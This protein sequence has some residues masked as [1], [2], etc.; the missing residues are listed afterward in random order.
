MSNASLSKR[1]NS[2]WYNYVAPIGEI[3]TGNIMEN[4][5]IYYGTDDFE[6]YIT[7]FIA[8]NRIDSGL[9]IICR[10][11]TILASPKNFTSFIEETF[12]TFNIMQL[13]NTKGVITDN[14]NNQYISYNISDSTTHVNIFG[15]ME[16]VNSIVKIITDKFDPVTANIEWIYSADGNS[17]TIPLNRDRL[18]VDEMYPFLNGESL[19]SYF[20][21]YMASSANILLLIGPPGTG[22]T[23]F[24]KGLISHTEASAL[25]TY[26]AAILEK[27]YLFARFIESESQIMVLEDSDN[28]LKSRADGNTMMQRF[29]NVG[30]GLVTTKGKKLIFT[31]NLPSVSDIDQALIRPGRCFDVLTFDSLSTKD[32]IKLANKLDAKLENHQKDQRFTIAEIFNARIN[33]PIEKPRMGF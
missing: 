25:V 28:F 12:Q 26:D 32:A 29:L 4:G 8:K 17:V 14:V 24:I 10:K 31:T 20:D 6:S 19:T 11:L 18:P 1:L 30:D 33:K 3:N 22:K 23:S 21:R 13:S 5:S 15:D 16:F 9:D 7:S 2:R 27:D